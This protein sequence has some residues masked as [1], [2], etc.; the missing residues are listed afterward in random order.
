MTYEVGVEIEVQGK[1]VVPVKSSTCSE[2]GTDCAFRREISCPRCGLF[3]FLH[4]HE[5][6]AYLAKQLIKEAT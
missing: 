5:F 1:R 2:A 6:T 3:M 4:P